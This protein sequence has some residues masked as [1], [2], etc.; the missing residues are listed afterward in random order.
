MS[1]ITCIHAPPGVTGLCTTC[2]EE[3]DEDA[4]AFLEYGQH[5]AGEARWAA[6]W[7]A[8]LASIEADQA[9]MS[10]HAETYPPGEEIPF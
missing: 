1:D 9:T 2:R 6:D 4:L 3:Y 5:E 10:Q 7:A 8:E